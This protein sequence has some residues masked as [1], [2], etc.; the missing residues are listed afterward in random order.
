MIEPR[1]FE[2]VSISDDSVFKQCRRTD[3]PWGSE[4]IRTHEPT[5]GAIHLG[6]GKEIRSEGG[7]VYWTG[8]EGIAGSSWAGALAGN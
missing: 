4:A 1:P 6:P 3:A 8:T 2:S 5:P 7:P